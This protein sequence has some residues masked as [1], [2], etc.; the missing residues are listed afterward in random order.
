MTQTDKTGPAEANNDVAPTPRPL[1]TAPEIPFH[2]RLKWGLS[3]LGKEKAA[4]YL[5]WLQKR[6]N[7]DT[8]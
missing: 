3:L 4:E 7:N 5:A 2:L 6:L 1:P 8:H